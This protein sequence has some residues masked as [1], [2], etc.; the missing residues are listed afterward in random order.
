MWPNHLLNLLIA[1]PFPLA[2]VF[3][4]G[5]GAIGVTLSPFYLRYTVRHVS[6]YSNSGQTRVRSDCPLSAK[7]VVS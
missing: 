1:R 5:R 2:A 6:C 3:Y 4:S 7:A